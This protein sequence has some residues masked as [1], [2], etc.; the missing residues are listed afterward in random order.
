ME[1]L[2]GNPKTRQII[3]R[4]SRQVLVG[5]YDEAIETLDGLFKP[6]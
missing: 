2:A 3:A 5:E 1:T 6:R 4:L